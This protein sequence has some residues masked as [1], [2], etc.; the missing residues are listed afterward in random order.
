MANHDF[1]CPHC[2]EQI[3]QPG[4]SHTFQSVASITAHGQVL[5]Q[6]PTG[7]A[8]DHMRWAT[9]MG[10]G[11]T[12]TALALALAPM[13]HPPYW[14]AP[15]VGLSLV[16]GLDCV[17]MLLDRPVTPKPPVKSQTKLTA[18]IK[19]PDNRHWVLTE[20]SDGIELSHVW[21]V[22]YRLLEKN[23]SF[24][25]AEICES[26]FLSQHKFNE[27]RKTFVALGFCVRE[28]NGANKYKVT[29]TGR[30]FLRQVLALP[31]PIP[32]FAEA[33]K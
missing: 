5:G 10:M 15:I 2:G 13:H 8:A 1:T 9:L 25:R 11:T 24:S 20:F 30:Q 3:T 32:S 7:G 12:G 31:C 28:A 26:R 14:I 17:K 18:E 27:I 21:F 4:A 6:G 33:K 19:T 29:F 16:V 23:A 22:A